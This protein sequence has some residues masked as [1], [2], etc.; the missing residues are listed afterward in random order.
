[1]LGVAGAGAGGLL[2]G[3]LGQIGGA[4]SAPRRA[5][6]GA[7][8]LPDT[9]A[10]LVSN[11]FGTDPESFL[12]HALGMGAEVLGDP[13]SYL[14]LLGGGPL[15]KLGASP[16]LKEAGLFNYANDLKAGVGAADAA[17]DA[18]R[19]T[20]LQ[21]VQREI[22]AAQALSAYDIPGIAAGQR[23]GFRYLQPA[24]EQALLERGL[25]QPVLP[26]EPFPYNVNDPRPW[27]V[28]ANPN[29]RAADVNAAWVHGREVP[30]GF[31]LRPVQGGQGRM[32]GKGLGLDPSVPADA[33]P[34]P[35]T[36]QDR[37]QLAQWAASNGVNPLQMTPEQV[38]AALTQIGQG[39]G[40]T[41]RQAWL[42]ANPM[43]ALQ[44]TPEAMLMGF[45]D[46]RLVPRS[47]GP[48]PGMDLPLPQA[49]GRLMDELSGV[50]QA[51]GRYRMSPADWALVG[52]A[53]GLAAGTFPLMRRQ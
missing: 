5:L 50:E 30:A 2:G 32:V 40:E 18:R 37:Q 10:E 36:L 29:P 44:D 26:F 8:G 20:E 13:L 31:D 14:G 22:D 39:L 12:T 34:R 27:G 35:L 33:V 49:R 19:L 53:G 46:N 28:G 41:Q 42:A 45:L 7:L 11:T 3:A 38:D 25:G 52:G 23:A 6:W 17:L 24:S 1:M 4:L 21:T 43:P 9:G 51:L 16:W 48:V 15:A 47:Q